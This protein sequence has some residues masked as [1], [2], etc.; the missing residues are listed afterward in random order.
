MPRMDLLS[1]HAK[2]SPDLTVGQKP[3]TG[4]CD[5]GTDRRSA[6]RAGPDHRRSSRTRGEWRSPPEEAPDERRSQG[7]NFGG[8]QGS[9]GEVQGAEGEEVITGLLAMCAWPGG[10][11]HAML[12]LHVGAWQSKADHGWEIVNEHPRCVDLRGN[13]ARMIHVKTTLDKRC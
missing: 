6:P 4:Y 2:Q 7:K 10:Q 13:D 12:P 11:R 3:Q 8:G 9:V 5:P 1:G